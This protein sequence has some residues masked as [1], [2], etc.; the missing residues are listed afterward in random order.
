MP[1]LQ[2]HV[3]Q[4]S[5]AGRCRPLLAGLI[6]TGDTCVPNNHPSSALVYGQIKQCEPNDTW[7]HNLLGNHAI[8]FVATFAD[9]E[10]VI[11][12]DRDNSPDL[13]MAMQ[14]A[15]R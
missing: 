2:S 7:W 13:P 3:T 5:L 8:G 10:C 12:S 1:L 4:N 14:R 6:S 9:D 11:L 15:A